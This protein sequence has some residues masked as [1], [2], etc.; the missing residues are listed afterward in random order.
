MTR[1][2]NEGGLAGHMNHLYDNHGLTFGGIKKIFTA[3][4]EGQLEGTEKTDGQNLFISY[5]VPE[6]QVKAVRNK[7]DIKKGGN[8]P[9]GTCN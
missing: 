4:A 5:S 7:G 9:G 2:L 8:V 6:R 3:A 1:I